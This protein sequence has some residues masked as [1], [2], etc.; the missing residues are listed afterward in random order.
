MNDSRTINVFFAFQFSDALIPKTDKENALVEAINQAE[1]EIIKEHPDFKIKWKECVLASGKQIGEQ[2]VGLISSCDIFIADLSEKN[3]NVLFELG[4][5]YGLQ[6]FLN[7][8]TI[9]LIDKSVDFLQ[10]PSDIRG[11][12]VE[13]YD[14]QSLRPILAK[15]IRDASIDVITSIDSRRKFI[16][17]PIILRKF[18]KFSEESN[19]DIVC[20]EIPEAERHYFADPQDRNYLRYA[21]FADLD[22]LIYIRTSIAQLFPRIV[23]RDFSPSEYYDTHTKGLVVIGGPPWNLK[24]REFQSQLPFHFIPKPLGEDDPLNIH[25]IDDC[26]FLPT[27]RKKGELLKDISIFVRTQVERDVH[28]LLIGGCLTFGVLGASKC[29]LDSNVGATNAKYVENLVEGGDFISVFE[30]P[31]I[32]G[33]VQTP[34]FSSR[35]P[36]VILKRD[37]KSD[38]FEVVLKNI[39]GYKGKK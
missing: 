36:L 23:I 32:G 15:T 27:W 25:L 2:I 24:F 4:V 34:D 31:R 28:V 19:I 6:K 18:W 5:A 3:Y 21:K 8:K 20:S 33:F 29:F 30:T 37:K 39:D 14:K 16:D 17:S 38:K 10:L 11:L 1:S 13:R 35:T 9:W 12:Y 26:L 22:S 7:K